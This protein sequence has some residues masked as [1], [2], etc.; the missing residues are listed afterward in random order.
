MMATVA[1]SNIGKAGLRRQP[2]GVFLGYRTPDDRTGGMPNLRN[3]QGRRACMT[4][5]EATAAPEAE[6]DR[7]PPA[8]TGSICDRV[9]SSL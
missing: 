6:K 1:A 8:R 5:T 3:S 9:L 4:V 7:M 2:A